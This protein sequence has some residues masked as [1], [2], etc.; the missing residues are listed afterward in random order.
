MNL[1][2]EIQSKFICVIP[3]LET[4]QMSFGELM[5]KELVMCLDSE[6]LFNNKRAWTINIQAAWM[7]CE[8]IMLTEKS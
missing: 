7:N 8:E 1:H 3:K 2:M 4:T 6:T 5:I